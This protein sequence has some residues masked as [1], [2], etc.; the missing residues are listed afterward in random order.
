MGSVEPMNFLENSIEMA[1]FLG[2]GGGV[3]DKEGYLRFDNRY[4]KVSGNW[5]CFALLCF[6]FCFY[7]FLQLLQTELA[8]TR[9]NDIHLM[10]PELFFQW[11]LMLTAE[12]DKVLGDKTLS[13]CDRSMMVI[14]TITSVF[15]PL[16][17][18]VIWAVMTKSCKIIVPPFPVIW[19]SNT[20][21]TLLHIDSKEMRILEPFNMKP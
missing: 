12:V 5:K 18:H 10:V 11:V 1:K 6:V 14:I 20:D 17:G 15:R 8:K 7:M 21:D 19:L 9:L 3:G 13:V 4:A 16:Q 2:A